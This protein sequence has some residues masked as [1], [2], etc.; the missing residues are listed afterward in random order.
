[1]IDF[2]DAPGGSN[3]APAPTARP[4]R[5]AYGG[6][7]EYARGAPQPRTLAPGE[8]PAYLESL[9]P[10]QREAAEH[11]EGPLIVLAGAGSGKT[12]MVTSRIAYLMDV[13]GVP[14]SRIL[15][16]TFTNK[17]AREMRER[18]ERHLHSGAQGFYGVPEIGTFHA[19]C[20]RLLRRELAATPFTKPFVIYDDSDQLSLVKRVVEKLG[21]D[22]KAF[23][24]KA[25][26]A[27]INRLKCDAIEPK[28]LEPSAHDL[29]ERKLKL[30][31][32]EYQKDLFANNA[33]DFGE[34]LCMTYR[35]LRDNEAVRRRYQDR[36]LYIHVDEYQDTNRAQYLL[37]SQLAKKEFGGHENICVVGDEDQSI[38]KWRG[39]DIRNILDFEQDYPGAKVVKLEQNY[40]STKT[41]I[42]AASQVI[43]NNRERK[44]KTLWTANPEGP[45]IVKASLADE[46]S[47]AE[48]V[49]KQI[50]RLATYE[51]RA[52]TDF[53]IFYRTHA[54]SRQFEEVFRREKIP[55]EIVGGLRFYDRK[56]IKDVLSYFKVLQNPQDSVSLKRIINV[57][58]RGIGKTTIDK[59]E[60]I[61][62][63]LEQS[64]REGI[65][66]GPTHALV[67]VL[68]DDASNAEE[69]DFADATSNPRDTSLFA[70][71]RIAAKDPSIT[72]AGTA[73]KLAA[74]YAFL[75]KLIASRPKV[76]LTELYHLILDETRYV[77]TL[78]EEGTEEAAAR[79]ENLEEFDTV[80]Q[81]FEEK[82]TEGLSEE[83]IEAKKTEL[84]P[85][86]LEES[87][88]ET[89]RVE[90]RDEAEKIPSLQMMSLHSSKG[91]EYPVVFLVGMEEGL[92]PSI[93][94]MEDA[95]DEEI[96]EERRLCYV[97]ITRARENLY[98]THASIRRI[99]GQINYQEPARFFEE[100]PG[101]LLE[102][103]D[104][105]FHAGSGSSKH[106]ERK[107]WSSSWGSGGSS[108]Y[109][110]DSPRSYAD[111]FKNR[112][113]YS[114]LTEAD[115]AK[116][117]ASAAKK[118][119][120][121]YRI[122]MKIDHPEYGAGKI[123]AQEGSGKDEKVTV[124]FARGG[125]R[126][127]L[128]RFIEGFIED[129][130]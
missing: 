41:I 129:S 17:A 18:V 75:E 77:Q 14:A 45:R 93:R 27:G 7:G 88:L 52:Y 86:F 130:A 2:D 15:A 116:A 71:L 87:S 20:V 36:F 53:A 35:I 106:F 98:L 47:E 12:K 40:R 90:G 100:I 81:E 54:Q 112:D 10:P 94:G 74:F 117:A 101:D 89:D 19:I 38:Y 31:Y 37:L 104:E 79:I 60:A 44:E 114:Q 61:Q 50:K 39:A 125:P 67:D 73:K 85:I 46:K 80:L 33:L 55:Y 28:E 1:M 122:G 66:S 5:P 111:S 123:T 63:E 82:A 126:K 65:E 118:S 64:R 113:D 30:V 127:F 42:T 95:S 103:V 48:Y 29:F 24:P 25:M 121:V 105:S 99:W 9:N 120:G 22:E 59:L 96:E 57:P 16:V 62:L 49:I 110:P 23:S 43:R 21:I 72:S 11:T 115:R 51:N 78:R 56:E 68:P 34:I 109:D 108:G 107:S 128:V 26:Q 13:R 91:L 70:A 119:G 92:F 6:F 102:V 32:E 4:V 83:E 124:Q 3:A 97:G 58:A 76:L 69:L 8:V 84:L